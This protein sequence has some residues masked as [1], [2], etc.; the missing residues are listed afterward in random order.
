MKKHPE[1]FQFKQFRIYHDQCAL[2]VGTDGV[3]LG[4]WS[5][6][7]EKKDTGNTIS[8]LD[9]GCGTGLVSIMLA[10]RYPFAIIKGIDIDYQAINQAK[11]NA[12]I[13]PWSDRISFEI[14]DARLT[15]TPFLRKNHMTPL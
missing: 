1:Y 9:I 4:A 11:A 14:S 2:K 15:D 6:L 13:S 3:L 5:K 8:V 12:A 10:Q 7:P